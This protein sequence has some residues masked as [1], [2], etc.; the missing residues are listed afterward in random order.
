LEKINT[1]APGSVYSSEL[2]NYSP[3]LMRP[4]SYGSIA[5]RNSSE[6]II[7]GVLVTPQ[8]THFKQTSTRV[9]TSA[10]TPLKEWYTTTYYETATGNL[11]SYDITPWQS[12]IPKSTVRCVSTSPYHFPSAVKIGDT[13]ATPT[14]TCNNNLTLDQGNWRAEDAG[15]GNLK[16]IV[17]SNT[18]DYS[19]SLTT[20]TRIYTLDP[21]GNIISFKIDNLES[22]EFPLN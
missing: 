15:N 4:T 14:F 7:N 11:I 12:S 19:N 6:E 3:E 9:G 10:L 16:F 21:Q 17:T 2:W 1:L 18:F 5:I 13:A 20:E 8:N 22:H